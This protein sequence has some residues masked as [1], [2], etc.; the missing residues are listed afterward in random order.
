MEPEIRILD[1]IDIPRLKV[2]IPK[3]YM[4]IADLR[5]HSI[6]MN[7]IHIDGLLDLYST[8]E[9]ESTENIDYIKDIFIRYFQSKKHPTSSIKVLNNQISFMY[10]LLENISYPL[11]LPSPHIFPLCES[12][13]RGNNECLRCPIFKYYKG[14]ICS[15]PRP[16]TSWG[17]F[18]IELF[19][20]DL[21]NMSSELEIAI[22]Q[23]IDILEIL[24]KRGEK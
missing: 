2:N 24:K 7:D 23:S 16:D 6:E 15:N 4:G 13:Y 11:P 22:Q 1:L 10:G 17:N 21:F 20:C 5:E 14:K 12:F 8:P 9:F 18:L 19:Q 3:V